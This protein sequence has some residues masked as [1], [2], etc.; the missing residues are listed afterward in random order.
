MTARTG[1]RFRVAWD[2][3]DLR[4]DEVPGAGFADFRHTD[5]GLV[6]TNYQ[7]TPGAAAV[8]APVRDRGP[9]RQQP[10]G[11]ASS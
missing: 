10:R 6:N 4:P 1:P 2:E 5:A 9:V 7:S 11:H 3:F 8:P